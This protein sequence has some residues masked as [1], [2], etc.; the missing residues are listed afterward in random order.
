MRSHVPILLATSMPDRSS[1]HEQLKMALRHP[2]LSLITP[3]AGGEADWP[4]N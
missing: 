3:P 4:T 2:T 1:A